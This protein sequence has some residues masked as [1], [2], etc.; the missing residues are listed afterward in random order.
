MLEVMFLM[1]LGVS[2]VLSLVAAVMIY[3]E[4]SRMWLLKKGHNYFIRSRRFLLRIACNYDKKV[5]NLITY[6]KHFQFGKDFYV[7]FCE[8]CVMFFLD[9]EGG[10]MHRIPYQ[11]VR[12]IWVKNAEVGKATIRKQVQHLDS[13][14]RAL[15]FLKPELPKEWGT[16][17]LPEN[18]QNDP[19]KVIGY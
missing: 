14:F 15:V 3:Y 11:Y 2:G 12:V 8:D 18:W 13:L 5:G 9:G 10:E 16:L 17:L 1:T 4:K 6:Q 19:D 7:E